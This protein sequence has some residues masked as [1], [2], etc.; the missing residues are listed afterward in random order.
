MFNFEHVLVSELQVALFNHVAT[1]VLLI[2]HVETSTETFIQGSI[3][4]ANTCS[5][6][7]IKI[8]RD[9]HD[10]KVPPL[11]KHLLKI[12]YKDIKQ[13]PSTF[14]WPFYCCFRADM[15]LISMPSLKHCRVGFVSSLR[16]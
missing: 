11:S 15:Y 4:S 16:H 1:T 7:M 3:P 13:H 12:H 8:L 2:L 5:K 6:S 9:R 14:Y 10:S